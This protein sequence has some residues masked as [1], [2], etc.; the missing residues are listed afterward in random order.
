MKPIE[1]FETSAIKN[2]MPGKH[3][4]DTI[5]LKCCNEYVHLQI[6][7]QFKCAQTM[8]FEIGKNIHAAKKSDMAG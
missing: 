2:Q 8:K 1:G 7:I 5:L 6:M 4:K 3:P